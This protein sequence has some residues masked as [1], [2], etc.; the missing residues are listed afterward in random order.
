MGGTRFGDN[1]TDI[2]TIIALVLLA[3]MVLMNTNFQGRDRANMK[4]QPR[5]RNNDHLDDD[6]FD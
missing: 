3:L 6:Y 1:S 5:G 2:F 4:L